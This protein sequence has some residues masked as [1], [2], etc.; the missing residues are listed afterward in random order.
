ME[1]KI[2]VSY[3]FFF[4]LVHNTATTT[5][6]LLLVEDKNACAQPGLLCWEIVDPIKF[7]TKALLFLLLYLCLSDKMCKSKTILKKEK[8]RF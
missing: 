1:A 7:G 6:L 3:R 4:F 5:K 2:C 8:V